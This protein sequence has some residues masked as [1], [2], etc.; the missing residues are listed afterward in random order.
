[1]PETGV[2]GVAVGEYLPK[3]GAEARE[4][5]LAGLPVSQRQLDA[6]GVT[7]ALLEG[8]A[9]S[10]LVLLHGGIECGGAYWA[11]VVTRL[12]DNHR[13]VAPDAPGLGESEPLASLDHETFARWLGELIR[14][15]CEVRPILVAH[16]LF[17]TLAARFAAA[18][19]ESLACLIVYAAPGVGPYRM[20]LG[21][22]IV[23]IRFALRPNE[24]N[25]ER[26]E[27]FA[28]LDRERTRRRDPAWFDSFS[29]YALSCARVPH[30]KRTMSGLIKAGT[31]RVPDA[32]LQRIAIPAALLWGRHDRMTP[33]P[34]AEAAST[35]LAWPLHVVDEAAHVPHIEQPHGFV[36]RLTDALRGASTAR[37]GRTE[38]FR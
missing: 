13:V 25:E 32:E 24:R 1:M 38:A 11:P 5:V 10:P 27:R 3:H 22:R 20:P 18:H 12:I 33:L 31:T 2:P 21:L 15:T 19:G 30:I 8:G 35:R 17:G 29:A 37:A 6:G 16:S 4:R 28:L 23:A 36:E 9:G 34:L 26:F 7:T 14:Q